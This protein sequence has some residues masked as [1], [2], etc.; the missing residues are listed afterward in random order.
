MLS[1]EAD[2]LHVKLMM[3]E[4][5]KS[6]GARVR[7]LQALLNR[8]LAQRREPNF[9]RV[10]SRMRRAEGVHSDL[11]GWLLDP[12]GWHGLGHEFGNRFLG[13]ALGPARGSFSGQFNIIEVKTEASTGEGP[14]TCSFIWPM[15]ADH[16]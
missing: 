4:P 14:M 8:Q 10:V 9:F 1:V 15:A 7:Q 12:Q 5:L 6:W 13:E 16:S 2:R 3:S 11:L